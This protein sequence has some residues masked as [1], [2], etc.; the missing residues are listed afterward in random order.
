MKRA[1]MVRQHEMCAT[2]NLLSNLL[3]SRADRRLR[4]AGL[5]MTNRSYY[6]I[7]VVVC[8]STRLPIYE[9]MVRLFGQKLL[10][11]R[12]SKQLTQAQLAE[13]LGTVT[14]SYISHLEAGRKEPSLEF[15]LMVADIFNISLD[16]LLRDT[17]PVDGSEK[18]AFHNTEEQT[19]G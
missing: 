16:Y 13:R 2:S 14:Q 1:R 4:C 17:I 10:Y 7:V 6:K 15:V 3:G 9:P 8:Q 19:S 12:R 5:D 18:Y 11:L